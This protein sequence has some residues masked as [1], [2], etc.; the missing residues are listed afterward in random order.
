MI[1]TKIIMHIVCKYAKVKA[2][3][4]S[5]AF[6]PIKGTHAIFCSINNSESCT[7]KAQWYTIGALILMIISLILFILATTRKCRIFRGHLLSNT[8]R[9]MLF[10]SDIEHY[11]SVKI[12]KAAESIHLFKIIGHFT[13]VQITLKRRLL[14][15]AAQIDWKEVLMTLNGNMVHLPTSVIMPIREK[16]SLDTTLEKRS[17]LLHIILK[18]GTSWYA[19]DSKEYLLPPSCSDESEI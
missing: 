3:V 18:Q 10:F 11:L 16:L 15:D 1:A 14:W 6:Q 5:I 9:V 2:L 4:K 12:C 19:L 17:L 8:V 7:C 13:P